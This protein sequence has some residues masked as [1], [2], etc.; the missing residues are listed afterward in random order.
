MAFTLLGAMG[1]AA[2]EMEPNPAGDDL[3]VWIEPYTGGWI[4]RTNR[5]ASVTLF[6]ILPNRGV[7]LLFPDPA[8][9]DGHLSAGNTRIATETGGL[10]MA[11]R[12]RYEGVTRGS[13]SLRRTITETYPRQVLAIACECILN[14]GD[15]TKP[16][17]PT[18][19]F[20]PSPGASPQSAAVRLIGAVLPSPDEPYAIAR[21]ETGRRSS[22]GS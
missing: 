2:A 7:G 4:V 1:C 18:N 22:G 9:E 17:G 15:L 14:L 12:A 16:D 13:G 3:S 11:H 6:E 5:P 19:L 10:I 21:Y 20:G 8:R